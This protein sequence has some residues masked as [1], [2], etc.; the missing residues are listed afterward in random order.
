LYSFID[1]K[2]VFTE[3]A[4]K[5]FCECNT[6]GKNIDLTTMKNILIINAHPNKESLCA[7]LAKS[8]TKGAES[9]GAHCQLVN[10]IDLDFNPN[11]LYGFQKRIELEPDLVKM[12][13]AITEANHL[14]F[15]YPNWWSTYPALLK[16]FVD[17]VF[18]P[19]FAF[20]SRENSFSYDK[21]LTG[22]SARLIVTM[23]SPRWYYSLFIKSPGHHSMKKGILEFCGI[24]PVKITTFNMIKAS[25]E[26]KRKQWISQAEK[27]GQ[28]QK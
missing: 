11:L 24:K 9:T 2:R 18:L 1:K 14:V 10:L 4:K 23:D 12:Q 21:L 5:R 28:K 8:Y 27:L 15:V 3:K 20:A 7:E 26:Q 6:F 19:K 17:R 25:N 13:Q 22:R 16:A